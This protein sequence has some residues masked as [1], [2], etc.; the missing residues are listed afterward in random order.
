MINYHLF[1]Y[2]TEAFKE[3]RK[4]NVTYSLSWII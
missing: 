1:I 4:Y 3:K 2:A